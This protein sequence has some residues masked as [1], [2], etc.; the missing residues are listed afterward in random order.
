[1]TAQS[2]LKRLLDLNRNKKPISIT[3]LAKITVRC[4]I[5]TFMDYN[6]DFPPKLCGENRQ[7]S[8]SPQNVGGKHIEPV[9]IKKY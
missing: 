5:I 9:V 1:M 6:I 7:L 4:T 2:K 3:R 8:A